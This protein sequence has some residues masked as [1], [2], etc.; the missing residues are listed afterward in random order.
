LRQWIDSHTHSI[1]RKTR[2]SNPA[3]QEHCKQHRANLER[4]ARARV[5]FY[6][7]EKPAKD[8]EK[9]KKGHA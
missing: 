1:S 8:H 6:P 3:L 2:Q 9:S 5:K 4:F 7:L